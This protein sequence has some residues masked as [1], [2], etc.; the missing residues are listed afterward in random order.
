VEVL[1]VQRP[2]ADVAVDCGIEEKSLFP[3]PLPQATAMSPLLKQLAR[4]PQ[5]T[6]PL[7]KQITRTHLMVFVH[8]M[9]MVVS[10][11][12]ERNAQDMHCVTV[13]QEDNPPH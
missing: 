6:S 8:F 12:R 4:L 13:S 9:R 1:P 3:Y 11:K 7:I 10:S 5:A 2:S